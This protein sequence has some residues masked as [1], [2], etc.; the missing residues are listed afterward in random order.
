MKRKREGNTRAT[1]APPKKKQN[2][3]SGNSSAVIIAGPK[4]KDELKYTYSGVSTT[5]DYN[6]TS[7]SVFVNMTRGDGGKDQFDGSVLHPKSVTLHWQAVLADTTNMVRVVVVQA[8]RGALP[9]A[10]NLFQ[11]TANIRAPLTTFDRAYKSQVNI[12]SDVVVQLNANDIALIQK[13]YIKG[14]NLNDV[15]WTTTGALALISG[16]IGL[17]YISDSAAATHP[18]LNYAVETTYTD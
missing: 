1:S 10:T 14:K 13:V 18:S 9:S 8:I 2:R 4:W 15:Y 17:Y 11:S 5:A 3:S 6:G 16:D 12:L 7:A